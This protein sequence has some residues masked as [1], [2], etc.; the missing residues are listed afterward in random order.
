LT[1]SQGAR[2]LA[3]LPLHILQWALIA[4]RGQTLGKMMIKTRIVRMDGSSVGFVHGVVLRIWVITIPSWIL[5]G[6]MLTGM[7]PRTLLPA[8]VAIGLIGLLDALFIFGESRRCLH[9]LIA[10]TRV[11]QALG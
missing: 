6:L 4:T 8:S 7:D 1:G 11:I 2:Q 3:V 10:G 9:D 5:V